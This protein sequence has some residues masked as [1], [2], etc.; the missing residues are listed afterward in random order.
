LKRAAAIGL[1]LV[2]SAAAASPPAGPVRSRALLITGATLIDGTGAAPIEGAFLFVRDGKFTEISTIARKRGMLSLARDVQVIDGTG[3]WIIPGFVDAHV[4]V[5]ARSDPARMI[6]WGVTAARLMAEDVSRARAFALRSLSKRRSPDF[7]PAAPIFTAPGGWWSS[8]SRDSH[9][10]R[11]PATAGAARAAARKARDLGAA[12]IK[13]MNDDMGWCRDPLPRLPKI[14]DGV[15]GALVG[16]ARELN[17]RVSVHAPRRADAARAVAAGATALA[18]GVID[19]PIDDETLARMKKDGV[20]YIPTLDIFDFLADP[21]AF[22]GRALSDSRILASLP[23]GE[24]ARLRSPSYAAGY[25][26]RYPNAA[27]VASHREMVDEN[28]RRVRDADI[29]VAVGT[30]MW[31]FPGAG[32]HLELEDFVRAGYRPA[33]AIRA[34]TLVAARSIGEDSRRGSI[35]AGKLADFIVLENDP[36]ADIRNTRS[37]ES[38]YKHGKRAYSRYRPVEE[39]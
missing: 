18:H 28:L 30:D 6:R 14:D 34:A 7:F 35:E 31:A 27:Y 24:P 9:L 26:E 20:F 33:D 32:V 11:F 3:K 4:H 2:A 38:V 13:V 23:R 22:V 29:P 1:L 17:L 15:F 8:Q 25:R 21:Q 10:D 12:E 5:E 16:A 36:L 37:I 39:E 19:E